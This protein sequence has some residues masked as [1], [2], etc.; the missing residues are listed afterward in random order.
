MPYESPLRESQMSETRERIL[1][2][3]VSVLA[4]GVAN[5][6]MPAVAAA[7]G[8]SVP[9]V[10]SHFPNKKRLLDET[11]YH[12]RRLVGIFDEKPEGLGDL[13]QRHRAI[14]RALE[15]RDELRSAILATALDWPGPPME[16]RRSEIEQILE[17]DLDGISGS[18]REN[19][20]DALSVVRTSSMALALARFG[21][22]GERAAELTSWIMTTLI[23]GVR[24]RSGQAN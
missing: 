10:Y 4:S 13:L 11:A 20:V 3:A 19:L 1:D 9:T 17:E 12:V 23:D 24:Q 6:T 7:A 15:E 8:V 14:Y 22:E 18:D 2:G 5:F 16:E 21:I